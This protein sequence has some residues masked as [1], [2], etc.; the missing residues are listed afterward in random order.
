MESVGYRVGYVAYYETDRRRTSRRTSSPCEMPGVNFVW[1]S[2][3]DPNSM[4]RILEAM[5]QQGWKPKVVMTAGTA[6]SAN[7]FKLVQ[8]AWAQGML[9]DMQYPMFAGQDAKT[10]PAVTTFLKWMKKV[11]PSFPPDLFADFAWASAQLFVQALKSSGPQPNQAALLGALRSIHTFRRERHG[12]AGQAGVEEAPDLLHHHP[13]QQRKMASGDARDGVP[14][15][16]RRVLL[17]T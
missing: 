3:V 13:G 17:R 1:L 12:G 5:Y 4:A 8:P 9:T 2:D 10:V 11:N 14:V 15:Q 16:P 6:Y 7:F